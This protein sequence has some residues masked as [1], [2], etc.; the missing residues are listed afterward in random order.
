MT[1]IKRRRVLTNDDKRQIRAYFFDESLAARP[2]LKLVR[3]WFEQTNYHTLSFSTI[4]EVVSSKYDS[5]DD[6]S[7]HTY[8]F[9]RNRQPE[10]PDLENS[11]YEWQLR[12]EEKNVTITGH[13]LLGMAESFWHRLPMYADIPPPQFSNGWLGKFKARHEIKRYV[14]HGES[15]EV[16]REKV[17]EELQDIRVEL[18]QYESRNTYNM[19]ETGLFWKTSPEATLSTRQLEGKKRPKARITANMCCNADGSDKVPIWFIGYHKTPRCF[20]NSQ[21]VM[22]NLL[23]TWRY[24]KTAWMTGVIFKEYLIWFNN[25]I[26]AGDSNRQVILL[27]DSFSA[28]EL[29]L[30]MIMEDSSARLSNTQVRF[31]PKNATAVCQPCDQ[32]IIRTWKAYYR[33]RWLDYVVKEYEAD[34]D[35]YKTIHVLQ[36]IRWGI[37]AWDDT[38][39]ECITNCW[40]KAC[41]FSARF[42]P[43]TQSQAKR[44]VQSESNDSNNMTQI[45]ANLRN[46]ETSGHIHEA[47]QMSQF[48]N[49]TEETIDDEDGDIFEQIVDRF[50]NGKDAETDEEETPVLVKITTMEALQALQ[51]IRLH[52]EQQ[53]EGDKEFLIRLNRHER[54][55]HQRRQNDSIQTS[56]TSYFSRI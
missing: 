32:G 34:K 42:G 29:G 8:G 7:P 16:D 11:L 25:R 24:N 54:V 12:M 17:E 18:R 22:A 36:A 53:A 55:L 46:L 35:P 14:R 39:A 26:K 3:Q 31:L 50:G 1:A 48:I 15:G 4:S 23:M 10:W 40:V 27:I 6:A 37:N 2:P 44:H 51:V 20:L 19:D 9:S 43:M 41:V 49:P 28:H 33:R 5:L 30:R 47:M 38:S 52:E 56:I 21:I 45:T 13:I